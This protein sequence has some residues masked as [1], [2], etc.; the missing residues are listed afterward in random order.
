MA[1]DNNCGKDAWRCK[2]NRIIG[3][4]CN[5]SY[6]Q[7]NRKKDGSYRKKHVPYSVPILA[8]RLIDCL[9]DNNEIGAKRIFIYE[10]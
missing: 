5:Q 10:L 8:K 6:I 3:E 9:R 7:S 2:A 4:L 1:T